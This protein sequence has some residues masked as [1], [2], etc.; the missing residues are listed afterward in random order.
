MPVPIV[1]VVATP[2]ERDLPHFERPRPILLEF[3]DLD[4][5]AQRLQAS[6]DL[7]SFERA[8]LSFAFNLPS[9]RS[10]VNDDAEHASPAGG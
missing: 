4:A 1:T 9:A 6:C 7:N 3:N 2:G 5:T 10:L 8:A